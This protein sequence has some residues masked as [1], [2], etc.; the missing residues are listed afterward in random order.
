M[1]TLFRH[2]SH[3]ST[4]LPGLLTNS[5]EIWT[6]GH[7]QSSRP[8]SHQKGKLENEGEGSEISKRIVNEVIA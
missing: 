7:H 3:A 4:D 2:N 1:S 6:G 5:L 8:R